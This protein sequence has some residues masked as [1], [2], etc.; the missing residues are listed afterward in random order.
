MHYVLLI[1]ET[2]DSIDPPNFQS[3]QYDAALKEL[4]KLATHN[5]SIEFLTGNVL[6]I[7]IHNEL[8]TLFEVIRTLKAKEDVQY[9]HVALNERLEVSQK[10]T[11]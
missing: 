6:Q 8:D 1:V 7:A 11:R 9:K 3:Q 10:D 4:L 2:P 5:P